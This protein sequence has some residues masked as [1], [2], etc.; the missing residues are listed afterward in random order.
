M[1]ASLNPCSLCLCTCTPACMTTMAMPCFSLMS[2]CPRVRFCVTPGPL[3]VAVL[4]VRVCAQPHHGRVRDGVRRGGDGRAGRVH[5]PGSGG[6]CGEQRVVHRVPCRV[7]RCVLA[8]MCGL[9]CG[10]L[11]MCRILCEEQ[12]ARLLLLRWEIFL[13][14]APR[15][16]LTRSGLHGADGGAVC[17]RCC[18]VPRGDVS[19]GVPARMPL[20]HARGGRSRVRVR[21]ADVCGVACEQRV[22]GVRRAVLRRVH[23]RGAHAVR[24]R[25]RR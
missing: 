21:R 20:R 15:V 16:V 2:R 14:C 3:R 25:A 6:V 7:Q 17:G 24:R 18:G 10:S 22:R 19:G 11:H 23:G 5:V 9:Y 4:G 12:S 13:D 1:N 8:W